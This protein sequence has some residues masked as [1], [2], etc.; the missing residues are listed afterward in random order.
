[1]DSLVQDLRY[2]FR[3]LARHRAFTAVAVLTLALGIGAN[4][5]IFTVVDAVMLRPLPYPDIDRIVR[6]NEIPRQGQELSVSWQNFRDWQEQ[7]DVFERLAVF[8]GTTANLT[9]GDQPERLNGSHVS[10]D[11]FGVMGIPPLAGR[12]FRPEEDRAGA[13][14]VVV[15]GERLWRTR[16][17]SDPALVGRA[18]ALNGQPHV[19]IG[20]MPAAMR[21]PSR[22]TDIWLPLGLIVDGFPPD[23]GVHPGLTAMG[24]LKP[25]VTFERAST[26]LDAIAHRLAEQFP[27]SNKFALID[28]RPYYEQ[29][30]QNVRPA[31]LVLV[32]AVAF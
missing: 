7:N 13:D 8:R 32:G 12:T 20:I 2:A 27:Q 29:V 24:I 21:F 9:G 22:L 26:Q 23:R 30:V 5:A 18:I 28:M 19:V 3:T 17:A 11:L 16:F 31:L 10:A 6:V 1:M 4:G 25:G 14:R 15:L